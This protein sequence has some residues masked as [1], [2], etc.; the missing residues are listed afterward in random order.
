MH[1]HVTKNIFLKIIIQKD[2][3]QFHIVEKKPDKL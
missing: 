2:L 1:I 3:K